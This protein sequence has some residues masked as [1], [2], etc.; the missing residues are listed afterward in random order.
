MAQ[1]YPDRP[2]HLVVPF[3]PGGPNDVLARLIGDR[4]SAIWKQPVVIDNRG[5]GATVIGT[6]EVAK[7]AP[8]GYTLLMVSSST[9]I[10]PSLKKQLPYDTAKAF[11][12][13][14][15]LAT[16]AGF[17]VVNPS[18]P[19]KSV[20]DILAAAKARPGQL[21]FG[22]GG[23]GTATHLSGELLAIMGG[24]KLIHVPYRGGGP[25]MVDILG[26][27]IDMA[28][29]AVQPTLSFVRAGKLRA[30]A[31]T[32]AKRTSMLPDVPSI[33]ETLPG[34]DAVGFW[35]IAVP[36]G[37]PQNIVDDINA[38][39]ARVLAM[40]DVQQQLAAQGF[41]TAG[42]SAADFSKYFTAELNKW[43]DVIRQAGIPKID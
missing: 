36:A 6:D 19:F 11:V 7:A 31:V 24:V 34:F 13:V 32:S 30:I 15:E 38:D 42:G 8:D 37:T 23:V 9:V 27:R 41:E 29:G 16:S 4:L 3:A 14:I 43:A 18:S 10:N 21:T 12:P 35:G 17:L 20:A 22:S 28:F 2:V 26:N 40:P 5:G 25:E 39:T 1:T 33:A